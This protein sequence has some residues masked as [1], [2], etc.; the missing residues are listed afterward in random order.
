VNSSKPIQET[1]EKFGCESGYGE[2]LLAKR[3]SIEKDEFFE[4]RIVPLMF[5]P[6][7]SRVVFYR[8]DI[9]KVHSDE[10]SRQI[11]SGANLNLIVVRQVAGRSFSH[12]FV[13]RSLA[14]Q[15]SFYSTR[16]TT[17]QVPVLNVAEDSLGDLF[18]GVETNFVI[19][20]AK[21]LLP[22][23]LSTDDENLLRLFYFIYAQ[24]FSN[25]YRSIFK[26]ELQR[27][28][29]HLFRPADLSIFEMISH[30]GQ[31]L[32]EIHSGDK[33]PAEVSTLDVLGLFD[34]AIERPQF[35]DGTIWLDSGETFGFTGVP[36]EVWNLE[37]G[38]YKICEKWLKDRKGRKLT[39]G[40]RSTFLDIL[41]TLVETLRLQGQIDRIIESNGG[42]DKTFLLPIANSVG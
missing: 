26:D 5:T 4:E 19:D 29:P 38:G 28:Y 12:V 2:K 20:Q 32:V 6:F 27:D 7:D 24:M 10:V 3:K 13:T 39:K 1:I 34:T 15:R 37:I 22:E 16:G 40:D 25:E 41:A 18:G 11:L 30:V 17:Y 36:L 8:K 9:V 23:D 35:V 33:S 31:R 42:W 14:N 21:R